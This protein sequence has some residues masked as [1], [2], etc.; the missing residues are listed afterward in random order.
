MSPI[1]FRSRCSF[2]PKSLLLPDAFDSER[3][4]K[5]GIFSI[6]AASWLVARINLCA[7]FLPTPRELRGSSRPH[8]QI[9]YLGQNARHLHPVQL[10]DKG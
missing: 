5:A 9:A 4:K 1:D 10:R 8:R 7:A 3:D 2:L 6:P